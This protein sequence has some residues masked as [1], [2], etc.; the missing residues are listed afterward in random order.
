MRSRPPS[1]RAR[2]ARSA[3]AEDS[4]IRQA[5]RRRLAA[6]PHI[7]LSRGGR[8]WRTPSAGMEGGHSGHNRQHVPRHPHVRRAPA[9]RR[10][11]RSDWYDRIF[12][13]KRS[14]LGN[15]S[16]TEKRLTP[17]VG[18][19]GSLCYISD[20]C[21]ET[22]APAHLRAEASRARGT[23]HSAT[24]ATSAWRRWPRRIESR[25]RGTCRSAGSIGAS[26]TTCTRSRGS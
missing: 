11:S 9:A 17:Q 13:P 23:P 10:S 12:A 1:G 6:S 21:M 20:F 22:M 26:A 16:E 19:V 7:D 4:V 8:E 24:S 15:Y 25:A 14:M 3:C 18:G 5:R 2:T